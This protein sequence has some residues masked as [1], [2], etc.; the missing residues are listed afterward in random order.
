MRDHLLLAEKAQ[1]G[2]SL[3][4]WSGR[5][6]YRPLRG[7]GMGFIDNDPGAHA[8]QALSSACFAGYEAELTRST[9]RSLAGC[10][11]ANLVRSERRD[12]DV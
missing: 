1:A 3:S 4:P 12:S 10:S 11:D 7:L 2:G 6:R 5:Q 8:M 9:Q